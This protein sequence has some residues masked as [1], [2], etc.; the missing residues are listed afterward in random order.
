MSDTSSS[1]KL[2][3]DPSL[4]LSPSK[5]QF[6]PWQEQ[7]QVYYLE[8]ET[9]LSMEKFTLENDLALVG[10]T[11]IKNHLECTY[12]LSGEGHIEY[13]KKGLPRRE[14]SVP[15]HRICWQPG[16]SGLGFIKS[17]HPVQVVHIYFTR[18]GLTKYLGG[19]SNMADRFVRIFTDQTMPYGQREFT[20]PPLIET[21][22]YQIMAC[23][24]GGISRRLFLHAKVAEILALEIEYWMGRQREKAITL[25]DED[26]FCLNL[27]REI[28]FSCYQ[29]PP[30]L[31]VLAR[32]AGINRHKLTTGFRQLFGTTV[33]TALKHFRL[34]KA[35]QMLHSGNTTVSEVALAVGYSNISHFCTLFQKQ[36][37]VL[38]GAYLQQIKTL[39]TP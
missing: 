5:S 27:A 9:I 20:I 26:I 21:I 35:K 13:Q 30:S 25:K 19:D 12:C 7:R 39:R 4:I 33:Y 3:I 6:L 36:F 38:P 16:E 32:K 22:I 31:D 34:E 29:E 1:M 14:E 17:G 24:L 2:H 10:T 15:R 28:L 8:P 18:N 37:G 23:P 11:S